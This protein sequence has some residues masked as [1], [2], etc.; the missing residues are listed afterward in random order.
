LIFKNLVYCKCL[1]LPI[2]KH[3][4]LA[5]MA[6]GNV[7]NKNITLKFEKLYSE[8]DISQLGNQ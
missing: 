6:T 2:N 3:P 4:G 7:S 1:N 5:L 8:T